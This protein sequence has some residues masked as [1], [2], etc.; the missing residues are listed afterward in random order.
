M[1]A[2]PAV[3]EAG[4]NQFIERKI[5]LSVAE[6]APLS[7]GRDA[8]RVALD[9]VRAA[10]RDFEQADRP[11][12][13]LNAV[14]AAAAGADRTLAEHQAKRQRLIGEW[15]VTGCIGERPVADH[16]ERAAEARAREARQDA[17][18]A[19]AALPG[20]FAPRQAA[21]AALNAASA[22]R[23]ACLCAAAIDAGAEVI[24]AELAPA[25][26]A[27]LRIEVRVQAVRHALWLAGNRASGS[28][29]TAPGAAG[30][31]VEMIVAAKQH[32]G[33]ERDDAAGEAFLNRLGADPM[34]RL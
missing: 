17:A 7:P 23:D 33:V 2:F 3:A 11:V 32:A 30:R 28:I 27:M 24:E 19:E 16:A 9:A 29:P 26:E 25:I 34:A 12:Q 8:L 31:I 22:Q 4:S 5:A 20:V 14:I 21:L 15:L 1:A 13:A 6:P 18:A 10:Q